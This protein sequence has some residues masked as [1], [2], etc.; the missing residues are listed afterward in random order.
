MKAGCPVDYPEIVMDRMFWGS[1]VACDCLRIYH[2]KIIG[3]RIMNNDMVCDY[4]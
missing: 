1:T 3:P 2:P 4:K